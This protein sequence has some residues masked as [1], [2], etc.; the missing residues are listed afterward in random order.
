MTKIILMKVLVDNLDLE[1]L[2]NKIDYYI[3]NNKKAKFYY[4]YKIKRISPI[5]NES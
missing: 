5:S 3:K 4:V 1:E 2:T